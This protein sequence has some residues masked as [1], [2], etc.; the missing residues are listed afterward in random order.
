[1]TVHFVDDGVDSGPIILQQ[2][3]PIP[4]DR[5]REALEEA[6]HATEHALL[7]QAVRLIAQGRVRIEGSNP[8]IVLIDD[9]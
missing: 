7:P 4:R 5:D 1:V 2:P 3:V 6:I 9:E 8:R